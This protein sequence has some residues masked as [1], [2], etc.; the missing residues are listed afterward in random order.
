MGL[1]ISVEQRHGASVAGY[2]KLLKPNGF[3]CNYSNRRS[4]CP[5]YVV[6]GYICYAI[7]DSLFFLCRL[8]INQM[9]ELQL[10]LQHAFILG[11]GV[12]MNT[13]FR[14]NFVS[15]WFFLCKKN[16]NKHLLSVSQLK[17]QNHENLD[18]QFDSF[19]SP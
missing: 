1:V 15:Q 10:Q 7:S 2:S 3:L 18:V 14:Q 4:L 9:M 13:Y 16:K 19:S 11:T 8:K 5:Y 17:G 6:P 12:F